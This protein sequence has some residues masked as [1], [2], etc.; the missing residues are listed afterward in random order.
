MTAWLGI[1][2]SAIPWLWKGL[3]WP[4]R[5]ASSAILERPRIRLTVGETFWSGTHPYRDEFHVTAITMQVGISNGSPRP[6]SVSALRLQVAGFRPLFPVDHRKT[7]SGA[8]ILIPPGGG[9]SVV[10]ARERWLELPIPLDGHG[11]AWG[12]IGFVPMNR[13]PEITFRDARR[14]CGHLVAVC[15]AG[16]EI[17][18]PIRPCDLPCMEVE[19]VAE[20]NQPGE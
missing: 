15:A 18:A 3:T 9:F 11:S 2:V 5:A 7:D 17:R 14:A 20:P 4:V 8:D 12:W 16:G 10:P 1:A 6:N 13:T 19:T